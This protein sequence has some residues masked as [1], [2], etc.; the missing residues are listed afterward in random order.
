VL[1]IGTHRDDKGNVS[2][3]WTNVDGTHSVFQ[4]ATVNSALALGW[5]TGTL[6]I[7]FQLD[8]ASAGSGVITA[9]IH[10]LA[11]LRG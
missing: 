10:E 3:D 11:V 5:E 4:N 7:N 1:Q 8:G 6:L 2:Y 9:Y